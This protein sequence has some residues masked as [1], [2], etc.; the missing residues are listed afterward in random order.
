MDEA[1]SVCRDEHMD[2]VEVNVELLAIGFK[3]W[4]GERRLRV[5]TWNFSG[6]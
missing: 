2:S 3:H 5:A 6:L 1:G 4:K